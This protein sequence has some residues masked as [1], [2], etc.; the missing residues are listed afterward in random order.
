MPVNYSDALPSDSGI[1]TLAETYKKEGNT[2]IID[3][4]DILQGTPLTQYYLEHCGQ[5]PFHPVALSMNAAGYDYITLGNHD[6]NYGYDVLKDYLHA[7]NAQCLCANVHDLRGELGI[8]EKTIH[9]LPNGLRI[10]MTGIVTDFVKIWESK[11]NLAGLAIS[12]SFETAKSMYEELR[13]E[14]DVCVCIYHG[15]FERDLVTGALLF[16]TGENVGGRICE[17]LG[18]DIVL[19]GH[20]HIEVPGIKIA[21]TH[22]VQLPD[23]AAQYIRLNGQTDSEDGIQIQSELMPAGSR[24]AAEP[25][26]TILPLEKEVQRWLDQPVGTLDVNIVPEEKLYAAQQGSRLAALFNQIQMDATG[27]QFSCTSLGNQPAGM[28]KDV[29]IR[30]IIAAYLFANTLVVL[31]VT[32]DILKAALE[33]CAAYFTLENG[34]PSISDVFLKPKIEHYNY[35]F[36]AGLRYTFDLRRPVGQRVISIAG[37]D[38]SPLGKGPF[39]LCTSNYRATGTGGYEVL[40]K[41]PVLWRGNKEMAQLAAAYIRGRSPLTVPEPDGPVIVY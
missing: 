19:T 2:L 14:C 16:D 17:E 36:Y 39:S 10:G 6:F 37:A 11:K 22:A 5:Y 4:G 33:R 35:D 29:T 32:E 25:Y 15:G 26:H 24:C 23:G 27:A 1:L 38:G 3:G 30:S 7:L 12:D 18:F 34:V 9:I 31:E 40:R 8:L 21:D 13:P 20:Q 41:C 28:P